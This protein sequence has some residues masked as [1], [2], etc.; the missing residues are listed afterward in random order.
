MTPAALPRPNFNI[1]RDIPLDAYVPGK[2]WYL[3]VPDREKLLEAG[4]P[5]GGA[6]P[7]GTYARRILFSSTT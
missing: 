3:S 6:I 2:T 7:A 4:R 5:Q 1:H